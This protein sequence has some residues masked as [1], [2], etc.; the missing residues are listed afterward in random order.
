[1]GHRFFDQYS[2][3]H[4]AAGVTAYFWGIKFMIFV[5]LHIIFEALENSKLG[6]KLINSLIFWPG[7]KPEPDSFTN[8]VGDNIFAYLGWIAAYSLDK[9]GNQQGWYFPNK[10]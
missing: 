1:M 5:C 2:L 8:I 7:G 4:F 3:L 9:Y 10:N 6:I